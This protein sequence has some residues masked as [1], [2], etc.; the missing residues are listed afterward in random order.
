MNENRIPT[1]TVQE[2]NPVNEALAALAAKTVEVPELN[3]QA[4][5]S[6]AAG[7]NK[8][9]AERKRVPMSV[10]TRKLECPDIPG[11][12]THWFLEANVARAL[13]G[14]YEFVDNQEVDL[15][16]HNP[17]NSKVISGNSSLGSHVEHISRSGE[18]LILMKIPVEY[19]KEDQATLAARNQSI[20]DAI[21]KQDA[22]LGSEQLSRADQANRYVK[23]ADLKRPLLNRGLRRQF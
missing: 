6:E 22:V 11:Y 15:N 16:Q 12:H 9:A 18:R 23:T 4:N 13:R 17:A 14:F 21:F 8:P 19:F 2:N 5:P 3:P 10:P 7:Q 1:T 20:M